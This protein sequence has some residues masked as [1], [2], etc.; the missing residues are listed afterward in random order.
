VS[1]ERSSALLRVV[2]LTANPRTKR[3]T[4]YLSLSRGK[5]HPQGYHPA[6]S[7]PTV[8][9]RGLEPEDQ[10]ESGKTGGGGSNRSSG[11]ERGSSGPD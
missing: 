2:V 5:D 4:D 11:T 1:R 8:I 9:A 10:A 3:E 7:S 6:L